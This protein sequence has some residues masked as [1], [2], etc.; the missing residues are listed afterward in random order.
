M[1]VIS[2]RMEKLIADTNLSYE[3]KNNKNLKQNDGY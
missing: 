2:S 3:I 1:L